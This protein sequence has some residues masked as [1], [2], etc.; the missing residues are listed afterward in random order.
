MDRAEI[1]AHCARIL[2][3]ADLPAKLAPLASL[4]RGAGAAAEV[5]AP[6]RPARGPGL[7]MA[8]GASRLPRPGE[9]GS[10]AARAR[11]LA[12]FAHHELQAVELFAW[13]ILRWPGVPDGLMSAWL[14]VLDDEQRHARLYLERIEAQGFSFASFAPHSDYLWKHVPPIDA[15]DDGPAAFLAAMGLTLEQANLDFTALYRDAFAQAGDQESAAVCAVVHRD[16]IRHVRMAA[17]WLRELRTEPDDRSRYEA[18]VP[19]PLAAARAKG[20]RFEL[21]AR[22][23]AG[24]D[25]AF[26]EHVR[27]ARSSQETRRGRDA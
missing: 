8:S 16:E 7:E 3:A 11:A 17:H 25:E 18:V 22:R 9:L 6:A 10:P 1:R 23:E 21:A 15:A 4:A 2:T 26:I 19:F 12:R 27:A 5:P 20:R 24:L 14:A 13:A